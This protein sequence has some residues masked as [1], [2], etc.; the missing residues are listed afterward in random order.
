MI[1]GHAI[2]R[3]RSSYGYPMIT[4]LWEAEERQP[5]GTFKVVPQKK[6]V[7]RIPIPQEISVPAEIRPVK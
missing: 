5:D 6:V 3:G 7:L 4:R 2:I 1:I